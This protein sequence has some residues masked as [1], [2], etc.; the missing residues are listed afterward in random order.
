[1][2]DCRMGILFPVAKLLDYADREIALH[3][4]LN[5]F[6]WVTLAHLQTR[7]TRQD[8]QARFDAKWKLVQL[9]Y[10]RSWDKPRLLRARREDETARAPGETAMAKCEQPGTGETNGLRI[11]LCTKHSPNPRLFLK[12]LNPLPL[13]RHRHSQRPDCQQASVRKSMSNLVPTQ[14]MDLCTIAP[15]QCSAPAPFHPRP[16]FLCQWPCL[17]NC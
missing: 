8:P 11:E 10:R 4:D 2:L 16:D 7:A 12:R 14:P 9:F 1:V 5:P 3:D 13:V 15:L 6:A 17:T